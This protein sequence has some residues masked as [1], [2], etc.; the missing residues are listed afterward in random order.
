[1]DVLKS[2]LCLILFF[3]VLIGAVWPILNEGEVNWLLDMDIRGGVQIVY[4]ADFSGL[5][6]ERQTPEEKQ[7]LM[8]LSHLRLDSRLSNFQG[9]DVRVQVL[10]EDRL[11]V[12]VPGIQ[13][14]AK[15]KT[16]LGE[17]K[18]VYFARVTS[19][20]DQSD[21]DHTRTESG[22]WFALDEKISLGGNILYDQMSILPGK[23]EGKPCYRLSLPLDQEGANRMAMLTTEAFD[24]PAPHPWGSEPIPLVALVLDNE[25]KDTFHV[26]DRGI[27]QGSITLRSKRD[28]EVL[29]KLLSSG[30]MPIPFKVYSERSISPTVGKAFQDK[31]IVALILSILILVV[32]IGTCYADRPWFLFVYAIT[33]FFWFLCLIILAN[34]QLLRISLLQLAGFALLLGMNTDALVLV[35]QDLQPTGESRERF[36]MDLVGKAFK[37]QW[38]VILWGMITT[39]VVI[40]PLAMQGGIF[41]DYVKLIAMGMMINV[42]G[43]IFARLLMSLQ[44]AE[45]LA[46]LRVA[47]IGLAKIFSRIDLT[48]T[49]YRR[50]APILVV[51]ALVAIVAFPRI[52][53]APIFAGGKALEVEFDQPVSV[54]ILQTELGDL[55]GKEAQVMTENL[56]GETKWAMVKFPSDVAVQEQEVLDRLESSLGTAPHLASIQD[57][58]RALVSSTR[59]KVSFEMIIGLLALLAISFVIYNMEA[60][61]MIFIA[62]VHDLALCLGTMAIFRISLD[63]PAIAALA[64]VAGYSI[65][66]SIVILHKLK[67]VK[68]DR[69]AEVGSIDPTLAENKALIANLRVENL[70]NIPARVVITSLTTVL[71]ML[72]VALFVGGMFWDYGI[73]VLSGVIF[74]TLSSIY[75]VGRIE[76]GVGFLSFSDS[77]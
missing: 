17:P 53:V 70:R 47:P 61:A 44:I 8:A 76:P 15:V 45:Q 13:N 24:K 67:Q 43:F 31:G 75:I 36:R 40:V 5:E 7:R 16:D 48:G 42:L 27:R 68:L 20:A 1:M 73:V 72:I 37:T 58:S 21:E 65:N 30:P 59:L 12:E 29:K 11:M 69:E 64:L 14:I 35:F 77:R 50:V 56:G 4:Q 39:V 34:L 74:G 38:M 46:R 25:L 33:I 9:A 62:L 23:D 41:K 18:V 49:L 32:F 26:R 3:G 71:P 55:L 52:P 10:G 51:I 6:L 60:G 66:D 28:A 22:T 57:I 63:L 2:I 19:V 54:D